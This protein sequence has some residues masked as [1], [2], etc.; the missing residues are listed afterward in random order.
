MTDEKKP[1]A[2]APAGSQQ[3]QLGIGTL[4]IIALIVTMCS[5]RSETEKVQKD[6]A[7]IKQQVGEINRKLDELAS[8]TTSAPPA[9]V[10]APDA[11]TSPA[12]ATPSR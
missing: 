5:G 6:T 12:Q 9:N 1:E 10:E 2:P 11:A 7:Q 4:I 3:V 8:K